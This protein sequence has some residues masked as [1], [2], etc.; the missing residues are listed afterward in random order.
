MA[1]NLSELWRQALDAFEN[2]DWDKALRRC[3]VILQGVPGNFEARMKVA[4]ILLKQGLLD[5]AKEVYK[6]IGWHFTKAGYPL[7]AIVAIKMLTAFEEQYNDVLEVLAQLYG[8]GSDRVF[9]DAE[10]PRPMSLDD[11]EL[12]AAGRNI[13]QVLAL[14]GKPLAELA[15]KLAMDDS[16]FDTY[17]EKLPEIPLFSDLPPDAFASVLK[18]MNLRRFAGNGVIIKEGTTGESFFILARGEVEVTKK[19]GD[20]QMVLAR[21][22]D[23]AVFGEMALM[24]S[25]PRAATVR[26]LSHLDLLELRRDDLE[27]EALKLH[28]VSKALTKFTRARMLNNLMAMSSVFRALPAKARHEL[29]ERFISTDVPKGKVIIEEGTRGLGLFVVLRGEVEIKKRDKE[30]LVP[31]ALLREGDVFG[32]ISL[33]RSVPT[34]ATVIAG[35]DSELLFLSRKAFDEYVGKNPKLVQTLEQIS[36]ERLK[37]TASL[38][39]ETDFLSDDDFVLL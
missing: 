38:M 34:T 9:Q 1:E 5:S 39:S 16:G 19:V 24:S 14:E 33:V 8:A 4:D 18:R 13:D 27:D 12:T 28:S 32:E 25:Q 7:L 30:T 11:L 26:A 21:L 17:P 31:L 15:A 10:P 20:E 3:I 29:L 36:D 23:G 2:Q 37:E 6:V 35:A 22:S